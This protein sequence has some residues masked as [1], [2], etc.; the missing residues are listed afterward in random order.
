MGNKKFIKDYKI[1]SNLQFSNAQK[2]N[3]KLQ[4]IYKKSSQVNNVL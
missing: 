4:K 2:N 3:K 1:T